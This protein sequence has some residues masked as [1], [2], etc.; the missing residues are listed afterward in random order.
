MKGRC[1]M[2]L[3]NWFAKG[4]SKEAY[5]NDLDKHREDF[6]KV[7]QHFEIPEED[8]G[9]LQAK[10]GL[11]VIV[12][13]EVWCGHCMLNVPVLLRMMETANIPVSFLPRDEH[14]ELMDQYLTHNKRFI[15]IFIFIDKE[16][17]EIEKWGPMAPEV[18][19]YANKL[20]KNLPPKEDPNYKQAFQKYA[21]TISEAFT[22]DDTYWNIVY[23]D[24][25]NVLP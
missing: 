22:K 11:R 10:S 18:E 13:A 1:F 6:Q 25:K 14:L 3:N 2:S 17:N 8:Q 21:N 12:L 9:I 23:E 4:I 7:Y 16:G 19:T 5:M 24:I 20:K 15:P